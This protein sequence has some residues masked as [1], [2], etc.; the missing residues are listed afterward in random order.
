MKELAA[1]IDNRL[2]ERKAAC[3]QDFQQMVRTGGAIAIG[4]LLQEV[5]LFFELGYRL[6]EG[7]DY[8]R[9]NP[10]S[11]FGQILER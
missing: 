1:A 8:P 2:V 11:E 3:F 9:W 7:H 4:G 6:A 5:R 10:K